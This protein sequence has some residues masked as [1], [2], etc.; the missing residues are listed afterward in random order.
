METTQRPNNNNNNNDN[1]ANIVYY[2]NS[3]YEMQPS[4]IMWL[5]VTMASRVLGLQ[6]EMTSRHGG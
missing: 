1:T 5:P 4:H 6:M 3:Y 2:L